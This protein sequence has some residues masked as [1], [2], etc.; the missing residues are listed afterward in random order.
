MVPGARAAEAKNVARAEARATFFAISPGTPEGPMGPGT[1]A[2]EA[3]NVA[4]A[5]ARATFFAT[6][7]RALGGTHGPQRKGRGSEKCCA[8]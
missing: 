8:R 4:R 5:E 3:K 7:P 1:R 6:S 2:A